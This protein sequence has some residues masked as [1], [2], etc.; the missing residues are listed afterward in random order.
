MT[1]GLPTLLDIANSTGDDGIA[2]LIEEVV[3]YVPEFNAR[4][5]R[6]I[7]GIQYKTTVRT[8]LPAAGFRQANKGAKASRSTYEPRLFD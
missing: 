5:A 8:A 4:A 3:R 7:K 2:G 1:T 6:T